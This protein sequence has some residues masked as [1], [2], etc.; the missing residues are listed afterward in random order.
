[1]PLLISSIVCLIAS[2]VGAICGIGGGVIIKPILDATGIMGVSEASFASGCTVLAMSVIS[3]YRRLKSSNEK[4][5]LHRVTPIAVGAVLGGLLGKVLFEQLCAAVSEQLAG[6]IQS[7]ILLVLTG[8]TLTY[9]VFKAKILPKDMQSKVIGLVTGLLLGLL[10]AFL[11]IGGG[12]MNLAVL[13][14]LFRMDVKTAAYN[15]LYIILLSQ[16]A[17]FVRTAAG[18]NI[19]ACD[20]R[21]L[22]GMIVAGIVGGCIGSA[23]NRRLDERIVD[24]LFQVLLVVIMGICFYNIVFS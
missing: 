16:A 7:G 14:F 15:S 19:P 20:G 22:A 2:V 17:S 5:E 10:S 11:G 3:V 6:S 1:M 24:T 9:T 12:P 8:M 13:M 18:G 4:L 21:L 23:M